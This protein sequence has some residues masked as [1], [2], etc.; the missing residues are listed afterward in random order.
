MKLAGNGMLT[1][2]NEIA[3]TVERCPSSLR[4]CVGE[5]VTSV[6]GSGTSAKFTTEETYNGLPASG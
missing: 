4:V 5:R 6:C 2:S 3:I 1:P